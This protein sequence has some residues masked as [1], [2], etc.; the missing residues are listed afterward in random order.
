MAENITSARWDAVTTRLVDYMLAENVLEVPRDRLGDLADVAQEMVETNTLVETDGRFAFFHES[1]FDY[2][3]AQRF[4]SGDESLP[5]A[6]ARGEQPLSLCPLVRRVL[7][8]QRN[9]SFPRYIET[10]RLLL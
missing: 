4:L 7:Q 5:D 1:L 6:I 2:F 8:T 9:E 10:V 3:V